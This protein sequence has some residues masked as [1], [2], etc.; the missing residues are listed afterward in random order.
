MLYSLHSF[1]L[2]SQICIVFLLLCFL[3]TN[4]VIIIVTD[5]DMTDSECESDT[6]SKIQ[7][8]MDT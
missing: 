1:A 2:V 5:R 4:V 6:F 3:Y 8:P 7:N